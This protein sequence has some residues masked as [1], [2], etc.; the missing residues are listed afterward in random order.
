MVRNFTSEMSPD[1]FEPITHRTFQGH[2]PR[3]PHRRSYV[4]DARRIGPGVTHGE[5]VTTRIVLMPHSRRL[6][7]HRAQ[8][9]LREHRG[10][11]GTDRA[12]QPAVGVETFGEVP[13]GDLAPVRHP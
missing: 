5:G 9:V 12:V 11:R 8:S 2:A 4:L 10:T 6:P 7:G 1:R 13:E 3:L